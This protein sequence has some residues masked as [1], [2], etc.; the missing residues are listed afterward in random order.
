MRVRIVSY[1]DIHGWILGKF[2]R[3]LQEELALLGMEVDIAKTADPAADINHH[4]IYLGYESYTGGVETL[5]ITHVDDVRKLSLIKEQLKTAHVGICMSAET[6]HQLSGAGVPRNKLCFVNP[7]H[8][9]VIKPE[10]IAIGITSKVQ[11]DGCKR[12]HLLLELADNISPSDFQFKIMGMGWE[13]IIAKM[14]AKGFHV[15]Y[16]NDFDYEEYVKLIPS[17]DY[18]LYLGQDEGSMGFI[19]ALA[20]GVKT[21]V[22]PQGY[23]LD[24]KDAITHSFNTKEELCA[25]FN[26]IKAQ[27]DKL[28]NSIADWTWKDYANKH[29]EVWQYLMRQQAKP[30]GEA[31]I[32]SNYVDGLNSLIDSTSGE[33]KSVSQIDYKIKLYQGTSRRVFFSLKKIKDLPTLKRKVQRFFSSK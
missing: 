19:D 1:E 30:S 32:E 2:A 4:I 10:P 7:A 24:A 6:M 20:A 12:E 29:L 13:G 28:I 14:K 5:M 3:K 27:R 17:L 26:I 11:P 15:T 8:D 23:H 9:G 25:Q 22:T 18:Y 31:N 16:F 33:G 21:I